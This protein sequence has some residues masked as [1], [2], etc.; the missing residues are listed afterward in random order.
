MLFFF[1]RRIFVVLELSTLVLVLII[2]ISTVLGFSSL[3]VGGAVVV[4]LRTDRLVDEVGY[5]Y[6]YP[7]IGA[8]TKNMLLNHSSIICSTALRSVVAW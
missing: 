4:K 7:P 3:Y 6:R 8:F 1:L 2:V 5:C